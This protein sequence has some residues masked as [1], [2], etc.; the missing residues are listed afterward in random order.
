MRI[1]MTDL[2]VLEVALLVSIILIIY[3]LLRW[4]ILVAT[5]QDR[6]D[7]GSDAIHL[8]FDQRLTENDKNSIIK[9]TSLM[10]HSF[11]PWVF[12]FTMIICVLLPLRVPKRAAHEDADF[13][14]HVQRVRFQ[15]LLAV[16]SAS[17]IAFAIGMFALGLGIFLHSSFP[18]VKLSASQ[19][20]GLQFVENLRFVGGAE[21][22]EKAYANRGKFTS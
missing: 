19:P 6:V 7:V 18:M 10:Y 5:H 14:K 13:E 22:F 4:K 16:L 2:N 21:M 8:C 9:M 3:R 15:L 11:A 1:V 20:R 17:P 12:A